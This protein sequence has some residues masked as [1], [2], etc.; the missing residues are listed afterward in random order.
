[1]YSARQLRVISICLWNGCF[2]VM[3]HRM[4]LNKSI[5]IKEELESM[6]LQTLSD[7]EAAQKKITVKIKEL[8]KEGKISASCTLES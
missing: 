2:Q 5:Q 7:V 1:M 4:L 3:F 6:K 8:E